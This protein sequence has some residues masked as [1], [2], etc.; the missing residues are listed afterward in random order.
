[1]VVAAVVDPLPRE[2]RA[3]LVAFGRVVIDHVQNHLDSRGVQGADHRLE[4]DELLVGIGRGE[5]A[6][7][8]REEAQRV[9]APVVDAAL[10][11]QE[12]LIDVVVNRQELDGRD[13]QVRQVLDRRLAGQAGIGA[14]QLL[15]HAGHELG[16]ALDVQL[17]D[18][19]LFPGR[20]RA[21]VVAPGKGGIDNCGQRRKLA[22]VALVESQVGVLVADCVA[23]QASRPTSGRGRWP[24][25]TDRAGACAD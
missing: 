4:L 13:A 8:G 15:R 3:E 22:V 24:W 1:M 9:V 23:E 6:R 5:I 14:P 19:R 17:V 7:V 2:R 11:D 21:L 25:H 20:V 16:E 12:P 18:D 10:L